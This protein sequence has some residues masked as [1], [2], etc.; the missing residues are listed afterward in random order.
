VAVEW[1]LTNIE[2]NELGRTDRLD[3][4]AAR[5]YNHGTGTLDGAGKQ[6][7]YSQRDKHYTPLF[8]D[9]FDTHNQ[10]SSSSTIR[11]N[12]NVSGYSFRVLEQDVLRRSFGFSSLKTRLKQFK[13]SG[14]T[15]AQID[16]L[17][18]FYSEL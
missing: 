4:L 15:D 5:N 18:D 12:D 17:V 7:W 11:P 3:N 8:I 9:L 10:G 14:V 1:R 16:E 2:Y 13:P 6:S